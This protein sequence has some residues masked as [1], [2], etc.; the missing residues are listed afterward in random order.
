LVS[1]LFIGTALNGLMHLPYALQLA[2]GWTSL[3]FYSNVISVILLIPLLFIATS[4]YGAVGA[5]AIWIVLNSGYVLIQLQV[6]HRRLLKRELWRWYLEDVG[7][8]LVAAFSVIGIGRLIIHGDLPAPV[9]LVSLII[10]FA[11]ALGFAAL[12]APHIRTWV[13]AKIV[14]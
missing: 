10:T 12:A 8:P 2:H 4:N 1:L 13:F 7:L 9:M 5:A 6:M 3:A 14:K 11:L